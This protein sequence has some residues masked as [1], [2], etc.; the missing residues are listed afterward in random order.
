LGHK[1]SLFTTQPVV[2]ETANVEEERD[3]RSCE[4]IMLVPCNVKEEFWREVTEELV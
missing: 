2:E 4:H 3:E 1:T